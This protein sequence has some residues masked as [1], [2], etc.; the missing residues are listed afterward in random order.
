[1]KEMLVSRA[2]S[3][4]TD[5]GIGCPGFGLLVMYFFFCCGKL[6]QNPRTKDI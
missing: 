1:M 6:L 4:S 2:E 5:I 3:G